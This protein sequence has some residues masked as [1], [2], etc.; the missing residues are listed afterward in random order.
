MTHAIKSLAI[1]AFFC[2][3]TAAQA[4]LLSNMGSPTD[5][6]YGGGP[7]SAD[8]FTTGTAP[9]TI[10][11]VDVT[12][13]GAGGGVNRIGI[14]AD[15]AGL[16]SITQVGAFLTNAAPTSNS[17]MSYTGSVTLAPNTTYWMVADITDGS[18]MAY[19]NTNVVVS[20]PTTGGADIPNGASAFGDATTGAWNPDPANLKFAL[21]G[22]VA[23][24]AVATAIPTLSQW[25]LI[26]LV[27]LMAGLALRY[28]NRMG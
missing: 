7:D 10:T 16:P 4:Q 9:L 1:A 26:L 23:A 5:G 21:F 12:W 18:G 2:L 19:T 20:S 8:D 6:S 11:R 17:T 28:R 27:L 24:P 15:N 13:I 3:A 22:V 14:Y 25:S